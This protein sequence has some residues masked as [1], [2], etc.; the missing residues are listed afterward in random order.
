MGIENQNLPVAKE[1]KDIGV[2]IKDLI[3]CLKEKG[4]YAKLLPELIT[5]IDGVGQIDDEFKADLNVCFATIG[6]ELMQIPAILMAKKEVA[7]A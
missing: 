7:V 4:D 2:L 6:Y 3:K 1:L 5:A